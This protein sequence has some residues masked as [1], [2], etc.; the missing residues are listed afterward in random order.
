MPRGTV[1]EFMHGISKNRLD[2]NS[3]VEL[4]CVTASLQC[5]RRKL[6]DSETVNGGAPKDL[7]FVVCTVR[8]VADCSSPLLNRCIRGEN[9]PQRQTQGKRLMQLARF[10]SKLV[11]L[12]VLGLA[13]FVAGCDS[14]PG[15]A[16]PRDKTVSGKVFAEE[17][18]E[19]QQERINAKR[20]ARGLRPIT[21][22]EP[23]KAPAPGGGPG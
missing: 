8:R 12:L 20:A 4:F 9:S 2:L 23:A 18:K 11:L 6:D 10:V 5:C 3:R 16:P 22:P 14:G 1:W 21:A 7:L 17:R 15:Q 13:A 19:L